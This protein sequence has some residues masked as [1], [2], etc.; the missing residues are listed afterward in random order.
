MVTAPVSNASFTITPDPGSE[1][2]PRGVLAA[3]LLKITSVDGFKG[4]VKLTCSGGPAGAQCADFPMTVPVNGTAYAIS[5]IVF[6]ANTTPGTYTITFTG[7]S[8][9]LTNTAT[10]KFTVVK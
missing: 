6:P 8:G 4:N 3:F 7:T 5:G 9:S 10:A 1:T 2:I